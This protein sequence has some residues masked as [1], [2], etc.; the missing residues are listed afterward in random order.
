[1]DI[2]NCVNFKDEKEWK[3]EMKNLYQTYVLNQEIK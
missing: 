2:H 1:M 3:T